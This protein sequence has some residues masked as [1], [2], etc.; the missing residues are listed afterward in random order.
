[1]PIIAFETR[2]AA[3]CVS[4]CGFCLFVLQCGYHLS[5]TGSS[6]PEHIQTISV[7]MFKN[8]TTRYELDLKL[9]QRVI[10]EL[11][12]RGKVEIA[13]EEESADALLLGEIQSFRAIPVAFSGESAAD[14]YNIIIVTKIVLRDNVSR[15]VIYSNP[16]MVYQYEYGVPEGTDFE[17]VESL[18]IDVV[19]ERF[20]RS[21]VSTI[22]EGF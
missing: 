11:V 4:L 16:S 2:L 7:P 18:A 12:A 9:T 17:S 22:L 10:D 8:M 21:L 19:A 3:L 5:G 14:R 15:K 20:A 1:M 13:I 6:L